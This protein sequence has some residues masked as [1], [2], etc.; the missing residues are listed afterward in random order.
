MNTNS[1]KGTATTGVPDLPPNQDTNP[2]NSNIENPSVMRAIEQ[3]SSSSILSGSVQEGGHTT[4]GVPAIR[5]H[6]VSIS[7][8]AEASV[9]AKDEHEND[10][11]INANISFSPTSQKGQNVLGN[12]D[13]AIHN[14]IYSNN[15]N[16]FDSDDDSEED[17]KSNLAKRKPNTSAKFYNN[18]F[19]STIA[20]FYKH[21]DSKSGRKIILGLLAFDI[22][23]IFISLI[24]NTLYPISLDEQ[25]KMEVKPEACGLRETNKAIY[26][27][28]ETIEWVSF[29]CLI[30]Y[31]VEIAI[32]ILFQRFAYFKNPWNVFDFLVVYS[33]FVLE[34]SFRGEIKLIQ[35]IIILRLW[36]IIHLT[37]AIT[38][39]VKLDCEEE[40]VILKDKINFL[41][42]DLRSARTQNHQLS[43]SLLFHKANE[44]SE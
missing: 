44:K 30:V 25:R 3:N 43:Q 20:Y 4:S 36:R 8:E 6:A 35:N 7:E 19:E 17:S 39:S 23:L 24:L 13:L 22:F 2:I 1:V 11:G 12:N 41:K 34:I 27:T 14:Y 37:Q 31:V 40:M 5:S 29:A 28:T 26:A 10:D 15:N 33:T 32:R 18:K 21:I 9:S 16:T 38:E 42:R